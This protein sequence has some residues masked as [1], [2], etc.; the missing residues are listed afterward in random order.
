MSM[1]NFKLD[2]VGI[3]LETG[4]TLHKFQIGQCLYKI[5][6]MIMS[7]QKLKQD[8]VYTKHKTGQCSYKT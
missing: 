6:N 4:Q 1:Q 5:E 8:N 3:T 7:I 2:I